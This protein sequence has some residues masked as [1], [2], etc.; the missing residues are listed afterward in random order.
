MKS[1]V[2]EFKYCVVEGTAYEAGKQLGNMLKADKKFIKEITSPF[3]GGNRLSEKQ[4]TRVMDLYDK[5]CP[6]TND[7]IKGFADAVGAK[8]EDVVYYFAFLQNKLSNCSHI[9]LTPSITGDGHAYL[10]RNYDY[11]WNDKPI[12]IESRI[13]GQYKQ[14]GFGC[15]IFGRFDGMNEHGLCVTTSAG[16]INP[17]YNEEGFVFPVIVRALLNNCKTVKEAIELFNSMEIADYRNFILMDRF[18]DAALIEAAASQK[19]MKFAGNMKTDKYLFSTNHYNISYMKKLAYPRV[20]HSVTRYKA[21]E[22]F[23]EAT[24]PKI[25]KTE[26]KNILSI[27]MP[28]GICCHHYEDGMGTLWSMIFDPMEVEVDICFGSPNINEWKAFKLNNPA[29]VENYSATLPNEDTTADFW[30]PILS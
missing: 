17:K 24:S 13:K 18:G 28:E 29:G 5:F 15:Q 3:M 2:M 6:G 12:L 1:K 22:Y 21:I 9:A 7:E 26:L 20:R 10:G 4:M 16:V 8:A 19:A 14:I 30:K 25:S 23:L 27:P 11:N